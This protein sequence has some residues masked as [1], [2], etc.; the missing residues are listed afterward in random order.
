MGG[1][2]TLDDV[3]RRAQAAGLAIR[4]DRLEMVRRLLAEALAPL[5]RMDARRMQ[6]AEP[7]VTFDASGGSDDGRR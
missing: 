7:A 3:K 1:D 2:I 5:R 6:T 4:P